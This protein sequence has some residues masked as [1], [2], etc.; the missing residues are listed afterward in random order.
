MTTMSWAE[1]V[2]NVR[3]AFETGTAFT[4]FGGP[5]PIARLPD[6]LGGDPT[7]WARLTDNAG[8]GIEFYAGPPACEGSLL[9]AAEDGH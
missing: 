4:V 7:Q 3:R 1:F 8:R 5:G 9:D 6:A 2:D